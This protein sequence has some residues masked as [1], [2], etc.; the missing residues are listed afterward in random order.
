LFIK[1]LSIAEEGHFRFRIVFV[2]FVFVGDGGGGGGGGGDIQK[3]ELMKI[4]L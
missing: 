2:V 3:T 1:V 4:I